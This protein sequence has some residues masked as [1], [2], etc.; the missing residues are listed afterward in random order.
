MVFIFKDFTNYKRI[1]SIPIEAV[2]II[3]TWIDQNDIVFSEGPMPLNWPA[4]L[5]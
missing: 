2:E 4:V 5:Q 3:K 1:N